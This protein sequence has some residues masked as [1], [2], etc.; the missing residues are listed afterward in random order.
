MVKMGKGH[1]VARTVLVVGL[2]SWQWAGCG[3]TNGD[4][5][6]GA[7]GAIGSG[8]SNSIAGRAG[9]AGQGGTG[10]EGTGGATG[11]TDGGGQAD[12]GIAESMTADSAIDVGSDDRGAADTE[13]RTDGDTLADVGAMN[14]IGPPTDTGE[15]SGM[16]AATPGLPA[17]ACNDV[18][19]IAM[20]VIATCAT[21]DVPTGSGGVI[22]DGTYVRTI[23]TFYDCPTSLDIG[24]DTVAISGNGTCIQDITTNVSGRSITLSRTASSDRNVLIS[25]VTCHPPGATL[26]LQRTGTFTATAST[27]EIFWPNE[28]PRFSETYERR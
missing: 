19:N 8:N 27:L 9:S 23:V 3:S 4:R 6:D 22:S 5:A 13:G 16:C 10:S 1:A 21:G 28:H 11:G 7:A 12:A 24:S 18:S 25:N 2:F 17:G 14:D 26:A 15:A 20:P